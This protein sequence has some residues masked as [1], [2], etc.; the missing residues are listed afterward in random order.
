MDEAISY[1]DPSLGEGDLVAASEV[2]AVVA[3]RGADEG[4]GVIPVGSLAFP[5][6][7]GDELALGADVDL[8]PGSS[9]LP[10]PSADPPLAVEG[11]SKVIVPG[12]DG[13]E[14]SA[15]TLREEIRGAAFLLAQLI[16]LPSS[17]L[18]LRHDSL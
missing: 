7:V 15:G 5:G 18:F 14:A 4:V 9:G 11:H 17:S 12:A 2:V 8:L 13:D 6:A 10:A 1:G 16:S 3:S